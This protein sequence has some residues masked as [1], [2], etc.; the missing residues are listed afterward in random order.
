MQALGLDH[1]DLTATDLERS[2]AF[3]EL[4]LGALGFSRVSHPSYVAFSNGRMNVGLRQAAPEHRQA[5][6]DRSRA[7]LHHLAL[8]A[9]GRSDVD[10]LHRFL[11]AHELPVLDPPAEYPEYGPS[12]YA[13]FFSDPD[14]LK[15]ELV[16]F[17]WGYWRRVQRD[18]DDPRP[19]WSAGSERRP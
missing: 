2:T 8:R 12:Y 9:L 15:L 18:G 5:G 16:H 13:V 17:P 7:G 10:E 3:Y 19:R 1:V 14:G 6:H 11:L 4:V